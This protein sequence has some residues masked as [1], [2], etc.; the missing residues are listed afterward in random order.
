M[1]IHPK[2][3]NS[4]AVNS[5]FIIKVPKERSIALWIFALDNLKSVKTGLRDRPVFAPL[6]LLTLVFFVLGLH[7]D[8]F[9][10][11]TENVCDPIF[12]HL[13]RAGFLINMFCFVCHLYNL[14]R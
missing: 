11:A 2:P 14:Q 7:Y 5:L 1:R 9:L 10:Y 3:S 12:I 6:Y 13:V 4:L 8:N